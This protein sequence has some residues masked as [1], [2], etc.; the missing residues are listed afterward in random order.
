MSTKLWESPELSK[1]ERA[2]LEEIERWQNDML[3]S[4]LSADEQELLCHNFHGED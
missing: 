4:G 3:W 1:Q 2:T